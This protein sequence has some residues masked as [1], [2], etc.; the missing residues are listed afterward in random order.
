MSDLVAFLRAR[1]GE[2]EAAAKVWPSVRPRMTVHDQLTIQG[3]VRVLR[4]VEAKRA[5]MRF[6]DDHSTAKPVL[7]MLAAVYQDHPDYDAAWG[8]VGHRDV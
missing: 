3:P 8:Q 2:D 4:E 1:L 5:L 7:H 6:A